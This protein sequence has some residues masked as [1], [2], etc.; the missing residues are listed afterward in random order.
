MRNLK[1]LLLISALSMVCSLANAQMRIVIDGQQIPTEHIAS[2]VILPNTNEINV[3]TTVAYD[4][5]PAVV[6]D[7]VAINS[8]IASSTTVL[9][10]QAVS[11]SWNTSNAVSCAATG[12]VD[13]WAGT[14]ITLPSG[15]A[16]ITTATIG[17]H[18]FTLTCDGSEAG[19][20]AARN[21]T[22]T[23]APADA[24]VF[25]SFTAVPDSVTVG[26]TTSISWD[27]V[28]AESC[29]PTG[30]TAD[31][32]AQQISL[33][34][35]SADIIMDTVGTYTF[36]LVCQGPSDQQ[37]GSDVVTVSPEAQSCD[38]V[39][40]S[41]TTVDW[42]DFWFDDFPNPRYENV[43]N[44]IIPR[45]GY[46]AL[47]FDTADIVDDGKISALE[48]SSTPGIRIGA[49]SQCPGDFNVPAECSYVWGLGGGIRWATNGKLGAC[50][51][52]P[53][54]TYY[55]NISFTDGEVPSTSTCNSSPCRIN[56][57][58]INL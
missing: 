6:G 8:F 58:H 4:V 38:S 40:L 53:N 43:T 20:T 1:G 45:Q 13:G 18:T 51:L 9:A 22:V 16:T 24:V 11:F 30:G 31:W 49:I 26:D 17:T 25:T 15:S 35:G 56:L 12:G 3:A 14:T 39:T 32:T 42:G 10:G 52:D 33:P 27:I 47:E 5:S 2:I 7:N 54:T 21:T 37:T 29:T 46:L 41:G 50:D 23:T 44:Y 34:S 48:N 55:F 36:S 28:N 57:Q 19:D